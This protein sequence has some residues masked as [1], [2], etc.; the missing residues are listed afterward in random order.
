VTVSRRRQ[1][2]WLWPAVFVVSAL[3]VLAA[4]WQ[5]STSAAVIGAVAPSRDVARAASP[6]TTAPAPSS[7]TP[8][9][10]ETDQAATGWPT[11]E[12]TADQSEPDGPGLPQQLIISRLGLEMPIVAGTLDDAGLMSLPERPTRIGW[13][14]YGPRPGFRS[15]SAVLAG[16]VDSRRYGIGPL[17]GLRQLSRGDE[18]V[19]RTATGSVTFEVRSL[20]VINKRA[21]PLSEVFDRDGAP[22]L[23]IVSCGGAYLPAHGGYQDNIV[24]TAA[25]R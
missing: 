18:I 17:A 14:S 8:R 9:A 20:Q 21:L 4:A 5:L 12:A 1:G 13:Y 19:V 15:G 2:G 25:P 22:R 23:R 6:A 11:R 16:H 24:V 3:G 10:K 7:S